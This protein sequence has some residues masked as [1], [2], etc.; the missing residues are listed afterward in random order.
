MKKK[1]EREGKREKD[2]ACLCVH[3]E[4]EGWGGTE[5]ASAAKYH[6]AGFISSMFETVAVQMGVAP[7]AYA[8][9]STVKHNAGDFQTTIRLSLLGNFNGITRSY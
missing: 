4:L 2:R 1:E 7:V 8:K 6:F 5:V 9:F 3:V